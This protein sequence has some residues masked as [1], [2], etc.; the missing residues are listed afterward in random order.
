MLLPEWP[1]GWWLAARSSELPPGRVLVRGL[2]G[3]DAVLARDERGRPFALDAYCPHMGAHLGSAR[4]EAGALRCG[5]HGFAID[6]SG[7]CRGV[8]GFARP[9]SR[10]FEVAERFGLVFVRL[11]ATAAPA[12]PAPARADDFVWTTGAPVEVDAPWHAMMVNGFDLL[13]LRTVHHREVVEVSNL[14]PVVVDDA[15]GFCL[16]YTSRVT[17]RGPSDHAMRW[18]SGDRIRLKQT[19]YGATVVVEATLGARRTCAVLGL[20]PAGGRT[21][22]CGAFGVERG[23]LAPLRLALARALFVA[24]L[25]RDFDV[26]R[27]QR[28]TLDG[29][30]DAGVRGVARFLAGLPEV[31]ERA[32]PRP[33]DGVEVSRRTA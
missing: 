1:A 6:A 13:H 24:F 23:P 28:L 22:A 29:V 8:E 10:R 17:G 5:L 16:E 4:V 30:T 7:A 26:V 14:G 31:G 19:C 11:G 32:A 25:R 20:L 21:R 33:T 12:P 15:P 18:L 2:L 27:G 9:S 3:R